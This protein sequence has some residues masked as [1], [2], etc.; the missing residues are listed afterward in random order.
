MGTGSGQ[1]IGSVLAGAI[2]KGASFAGANIM[3]DKQQQRLNAMAQI[4]LMM[5][6]MEAD[7]RANESRANIKR[8]RELNSLTNAQTAETIANTLPW[9]EKQ[10][11]AANIGERM[12]ARPSFRE[13]VSHFGK[14]F[15]VTPSLPGV[16]SLGQ[17]GSGSPFNLNIGGK[18]KGH[19]SAN[20]YA[21]MASRG[22]IAK[23][24]SA[25]GGTEAEA[26]R[27][28]LDESVIPMLT[29]GELGPKDVAGAQVKALAQTITNMKDQI[30]TKYKAREGVILDGP[31][32]D[33]ITN[34]IRAL[35]LQLKDA[36]KSLSADV[37]KVYSEGNEGA[38]TELTPE[39][40]QTTKAGGG[41]FAPG[42]IITAP[43][44]S[45]FTV[46][47]WEEIVAS[48]LQ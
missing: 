22:I 28:W 42:T 38:T 17:V 34:E 41:Q 46:E 37:R 33:Q 30:K 36:S 31:E 40:Y 3:A 21:I 8:L 18:T 1:N 2:G 20:L 6:K 23:E 44:G 25:A 39:Q 5:E 11:Y 19:P 16:V 12:L 35:E 15:G 9:K 13:S 7:R 32:Y 24:V 43:D 45:Q 26:E 10:D 27:R 4:G 47:E 14:E 29:V 48:G